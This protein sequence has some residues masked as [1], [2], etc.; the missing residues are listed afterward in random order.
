MQSKTS[1][2]G[3]FANINI[4]IFLSGI[5][6]GLALPPIFFTPGILLIAS[7]AF[8]IHSQQSLKAVA[9]RSWLWGLGYNIAGIYW[10]CAS[11]F[12]Y[13][14]EYWWLV[15]IAFIGLPAILATFLAIACL[16]IKILCR[17]FSNYFTVIFTIMWIIYEWTISWIFTGF[18]WGLIG[19]S[20]SFSSYLTQIASIFGIYGL[21]FFVVYVAAGC[22]S[23]FTR[24]WSALKKHLIVS[25]LIILAIV[26]YGFIR[27]ENHPTEFTDIKVRIIQPSIEQKNKWLVSDF[28]SNLNQQIF[29]SNKDEEFQPHLIIWPESAIVV[30]YQKHEI[31]A[32][33]QSSIKI[34]TAL[35][36]AGGID[37]IIEGNK[38]HPY[39]AF[40]GVLNNSLEFMYHKQHLVPF[41]EYVPLKNFLL[42][43]KLTHG[44]ED[45]KSGNTPNNFY[46]SNI[47]LNVNPIICYEDIFPEEIRM[48]SAQSDFMA[49]ITNDAWFGMTSGPYQHFYITKMRAVENGLPIVRS[50]N[51]GISAIIDAFG[52]TIMRTNL[53]EI[54]KLD[55]LLPIK[56]PG[57]TLYNQ[58]GY[59]NI[60]LLSL[61]F[62]ALRFVTL[63]NKRNLC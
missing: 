45:Y 12:V 1:P 32:Y 60:I 5:I 46:L 51:N 58:Y 28:W 52:R 11:L 39:S 8:Q 9:L 37:E 35:L 17:Q 63:L 40:Y 50:S 31:M 36:M 23:F 53:N 3:S 15:P 16:L 59:I 34:K 19:Y 62:I 33:I 21:S 24:D 30:P 47:K 55:G 57:K 6:T 14:E 22:H 41:G 7:L 20:L 10:V 42:I 29:L 13:I 4:F 49:H 26:C 43:K 2:L 61:L 25:S 27:L 44:F 54:T 56:A 48:K 38:K 18:P